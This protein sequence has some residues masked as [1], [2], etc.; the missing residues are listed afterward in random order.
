M[1]ALSRFPALIFRLCVLTCLTGM[2][3]CVPASAR[4]E[5]R[6]SLLDDPMEYHDAIASL[7]QWS[8]VLAEYAQMEAEY[9]FCRTYPAECSSERIAVWQRFITAIEHQPAFR[10]I[11]F[12]NEWINRMP[13]RQDS[14]VYGDNDHWSSITEFFDY[15]GDCEDYA[16]IKYLTLRQL[17]F[18]PESMR[19]AAV[20]DVFSGTDHAFLVVSKDGQDYV[21]DNR[22]KTTDPAL[23]NKRYK[24]HFA[25]NEYGVW[26]YDSPVLAQARENTKRP[27]LLGNR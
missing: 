27:I 9:A 22:E 7:P 10:Q 17:G 18:Q 1:T 6:A 19:V 24:P 23:F 26:T 3:L 13:Y 12:V 21:L 8:A 4:A 16:V 11:E 20:Y 25:F 2:I 15:S 14:W 5:N